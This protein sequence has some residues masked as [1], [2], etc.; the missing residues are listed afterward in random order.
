M[1]SILAVRLAY[2]VGFIEGASR[3]YDE[4]DR[5]EISFEYNYRYIRVTAWSTWLRRRE[6]ALE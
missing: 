6:G 4:N 1:A 2:D 5:S 3:G